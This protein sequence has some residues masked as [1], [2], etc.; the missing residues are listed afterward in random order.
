MC[1]CVCVCVCVWMKAR[2][3]LV[4]LGSGVHAVD[5]CCLMSDDC[6]RGLTGSYHHVILGGAVLKGS[7]DTCPLSVCVCVCVCVCV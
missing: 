3:V 6:V 2:V 5:Q 7:R 1:V 4:C